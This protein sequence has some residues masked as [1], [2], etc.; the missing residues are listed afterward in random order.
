MY[1][2]FKVLSKVSNTSL[3]SDVASS[4]VTTL[5]TTGKALQGFETKRDDKPRYDRPR[6][7]KFE[8]DVI[9]EK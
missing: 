3:F 9:E 6:H 4:F 8:P 7:E 5:V 1:V 2:E